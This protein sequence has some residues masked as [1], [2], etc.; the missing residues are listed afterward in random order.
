MKKH[1]KKNLKK[2][3][4]FWITGLSGSG[5]TTIAKKIK[6]DI[7]N[8]YGPTL[9]ISGDDIRKIFNFRGYSAKKRLSLVM[10]YCKF[11]KFITNQNINLIFAVVGMMNEVRAWNKKNIANYVE[12]YVKADLKKIIKVKKKK[13]YHKKNVGEIV[14]V[15]I[16][17]EFPKKPDIVI[18]NDFKKSI[19]FFS[20]LLM[21]KIQEII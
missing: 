7:Q 12:I 17:P 19:D 20:S 18:K 1:K 2:G 8:L 16:K 21:K 9:L 4:L 10:K 13:I 6:K 14:G 3:T 11:A 5:K 15:S